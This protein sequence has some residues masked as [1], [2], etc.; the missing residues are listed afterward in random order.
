[1][2]PLDRRGDRE[3]EVAPGERYCRFRS[4]R[5]RLCHKR[6]VFA[7]HTSL[8]SHYKTH[9][10][11]VISGRDR[12]GNLNYAEDEEA[13]Q[14]YTEVVDGHMPSWP[15]DDPHEGTETGVGIS[16]LL[17]NDATDTG[18]IDGV[19][20]PPEPANDG[21]DT[22][23]TDEAPEPPEHEHE[24]NPP[25]NINEHTAVGNVNDSSDFQ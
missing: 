6:T 17:A 20:K 5:G 24:A 1:M 16:T 22:V 11:T 7:T 19:P 18:N 9:G 12:Y 8:K 21:A 10:I 14:W 3:V 13:L 4:A 25:P 23:N 2:P 15:L